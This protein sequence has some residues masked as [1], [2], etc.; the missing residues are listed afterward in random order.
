MVLQ[1][2]WTERVNTKQNAARISAC[3]SLQQQSAAYPVDPHF[4]GVGYFAGVGGEDVCRD[5][6]AAHFAL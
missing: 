2:A 3:L 1:P 6:A 5:V 4:V